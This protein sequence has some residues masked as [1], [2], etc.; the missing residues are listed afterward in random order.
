MIM[1]ALEY[2]L[3]YPLGGVC[4]V[5]L[6][7]AGSLLM[8]ALTSILSAKFWTI[9][10]KARQRDAKIIAAIRCD[11]GEL[12]AILRREE[13]K[14]KASETA[15]REAIEELTKQ[16]ERNAFLDLELSSAMSQR[17]RAQLNLAQMS[18]DWEE[19]RGTI[20]QIQHAEEEFLKWCERL[21]A[22]EE[23]SPQPSPLLCD[24]VRAYNTTLRKVIPRQDTSA[25]PVLAPNTRR[26][27]I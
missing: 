1:N 16:I 12:G 8:C 20:N 23:A 11:I 5:I 3:D 25:P 2:C 10:D 22:S 27:S 26:R 24:V 15:A 21:N 17:D 6:S 14:C 7:L 4:L 13:A 19:A 18:E 9:R